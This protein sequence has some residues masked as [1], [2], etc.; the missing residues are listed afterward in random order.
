MTPPEV[1]IPNSPRITINLTDPSELLTGRVQTRITAAA[2]LDIQIDN[3]AGVDPI[4]LEPLRDKSIGA[5]SLLALRGETSRLI[6]VRY[7]VERNIPDLVDMD[8]D[9][10]QVDV[11]I[12]CGLVPQDVA[13]ELAAH[14][15]HLTRKLLLP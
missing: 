1:P 4:V 9:V 10:A 5:L 3:T 8:V 11:Y 13:D 7:I 14:A 2:A 15:T 6:T 12:D